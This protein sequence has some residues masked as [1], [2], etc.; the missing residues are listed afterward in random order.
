[1][2][3]VLAFDLDGVLFSDGTKE[4]I[5]HLHSTLGVDTARAGEMLN[6]PLGSSYREGRL[7]R[8]EF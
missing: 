2:V 6:G 1:V 4:F 5:E 8:N 7:T 3:S